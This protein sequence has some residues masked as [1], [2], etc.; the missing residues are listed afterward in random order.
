[1]VDLGCHEGH[2]TYKNMSDALIWMHYFNA[3]GGSVHGIDIVD[4]FGRRRFAE[5]RQHLEQADALPSAQ[6]QERPVR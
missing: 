2:G 6:S 5:C 4:D 3:T 1:M